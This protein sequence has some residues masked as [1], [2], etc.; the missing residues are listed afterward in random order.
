MFFFSS[1]GVLIP[2]TLPSG[3]STRRAHPSHMNNES[4][5]TAGD[6][7]LPRVNVGGTKPLIICV[8]SGSA[9]LTIITSP[10]ELFSSEMNAKNYI[11]IQGS[12]NRKV[13]HQTMHPWCNDFNMKIRINKLLQLFSVWRPCR[14]I[15]QLSKYVFEGR[16]MHCR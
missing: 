9:S 2:R 16:E 1:M 6:K 10:K 14:G 12:K 8:F 13:N 7:T 4:T 11:C 3:Y 15:K 5:S